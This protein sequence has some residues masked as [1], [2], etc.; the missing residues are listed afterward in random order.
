MISKIKQGHI[1]KNVASYAARW[2]QWAMDSDG[3][4]MVKMQINKNVK[5]E[6]LD[7]RNL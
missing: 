4:R 7:P 6:T 3:R 5:V 1:N 2:S